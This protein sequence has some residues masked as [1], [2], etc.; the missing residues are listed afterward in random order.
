MKLTELGALVNVRNHIGVVINDKHVTNRDE[1]T[2]LNTVR[3]LL[4]KKFVEAVRSLDLDNLF[5]KETV[6]TVDHSVRKDPLQVVR[7]EKTVAASTTSQINSWKEAFGNP[8]SVE[9]E[10]E[11]EE[12]VTETVEEV[13]EDT[14]EEVQPVKMVPAAPPAVAMVKVDTKKKAP[15]APAV[16]L[17]P[18]DDPAFKAALAKQKAL[19]AAQG[20][21]NKR[22]KKEDA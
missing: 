3:R 17:S 11:D 18:E 13:V 15:P 19:L 4:D 6:V 22:T 20:R 14:A 5:E 8:E 1:I 21:S 12:V 16:I 9:A 7:F 2:L 10:P